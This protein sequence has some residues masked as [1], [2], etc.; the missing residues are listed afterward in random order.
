MK[1]R[2]KPHFFRKYGPCRGDS[3]APPPESQRPRAF[4]RKHSTALNLIPKGVRENPRGTVHI[5]ERMRFSPL[6]H[7][8]TARNPLE[9]PKNKAVFFVTLPPILRGLFA[10]FSDGVFSKTWSASA[11]ERPLPGLAKNTISF[12]CEKRAIRVTIPLRGLR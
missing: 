4:H 10:A 2:R 9:R 12:W 6:F 3:P 11:F 7:A 5:F 8:K 1:Q